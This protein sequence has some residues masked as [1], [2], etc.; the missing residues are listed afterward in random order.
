MQNSKK[1]EHDGMYL[2]FH[3]QHSWLHKVHKR[4]AEVHWPGSLAG[5]RLFLKRQGVWNL[6]NT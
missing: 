5:E 2:E 3:H 4:V 6:R 1:N